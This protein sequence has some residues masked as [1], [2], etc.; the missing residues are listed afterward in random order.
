MKL[1]IL[2]FFFFFKENV[3]NDD[4]Y[5]YRRN[6]AKSLVDEASTSSSAYEIQER[7]SVRYSSNKKSRKCSNDSHQTAND[8][9]NIDNDTEG[10]KNNIKSSNINDNV[11]ILTE[12]FLLLLRDFILVLPDSK[13]EYVLTNIL[14]VEMLIVMANHPSPRVRVAVIKV[15]LHYIIFILMLRNCIYVKFGCLF[16]AY[17]T[18]FNFLSLICSL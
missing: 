1:F 11:D 16:N 3:D 9:C 8:G 7:Q 5:Y 14:K 15:W 12:G 10:G 2:I 18:L 6:N 17:C 13:A 4:D